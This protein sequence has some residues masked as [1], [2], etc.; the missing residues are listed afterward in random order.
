MAV[1]RPSAQKWARRGLEEEGANDIVRGADHPLSLAVL[2]R[3]IRTR[4]AQVDTAGEKEGTG[5]V[6]IKLTA[7]VTLDGLDGEAE[8]S[9][10]PGKEMEE[11][12]ERVRL[13][14]QRKSP[15]VMREVINNRQIVLIT[16]NAEYR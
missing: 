6:V 9:S 4:H 2:R 11:G 7:V 8:L 10:D 14:T 15:R 13:C 3:S 5:S 1:W 16:R 12:G